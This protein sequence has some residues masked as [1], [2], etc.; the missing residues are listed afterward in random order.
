MFFWTI[1]GLNLTWTLSRNISSQPL[2]HLF[3]SLHASLFYITSPHSTFTFSSFVPSYFT[4]Y[5][6]YAMFC[7]S[8]SSSSPVSVL[9]NILWTP[10]LSSPHPTPTYLHSSHFN[11]ILLD[12]LSI[13]LYFSQTYSILSQSYYFCSLTYTISHLY[14][15]P[16]TVNPTLYLFSNLN[17]SSFTL[18][19]FSNPNRSSF[20]LYLFSN[21]N[22]SSFTL[23]LFSNPNR[24]S[25]T[26]YLFS[27]PNRSSFT[28]YLF[29]NPNRSS[30][31]LYLF[32]NPNR[33]SFTLSLFSNPNRSSFTLYSQNIFDFNSTPCALHQTIF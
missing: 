32:S 17:R 22:R 29:S 3:Y 18:F 19:L 33:S 1:R 14:L 2:L 6:S 24:S 5:Q 15:S 7:H 31:T 21:P 30:F 13:P 4:F 9:L 20:T 11:C 27:N 25:F 16:S 8:S 10:T 26:L 23:Y 12:L 28:L